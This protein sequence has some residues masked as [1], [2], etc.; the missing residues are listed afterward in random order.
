M[1]YVTFS[2]KDLSNIS[3]DYTDYRPVLAEARCSDTISRA[4][5]ATLGIAISFLTSASVALADCFLA[6]LIDIQP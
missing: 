2:F 1:N 4:D 3:P 6:F 5:I